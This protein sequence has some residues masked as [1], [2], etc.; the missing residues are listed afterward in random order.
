[1][2][3]M[4]LPAAPVPFATRCVAFVF[5]TVARLR[6][7]R[8]LHPRGVLLDGHAEILDA[9]GGL[10][11]GRTQVAALV[12]L[13]RGAG[14][15]E[16][17]PDFCGI[18]LRLLDA[19]GA[20]RHQD[21]LVTTS[22]G[23]RIGRHLLRPARDTSGW[24]TGLVGYRDPHGRS[25]LF[26]CPPGPRPSIARAAASVPFDVVVHMATDG[27]P[28]HA[29]ARV[30]LTAVDHEQV[31]RF[32]PDVTSPALVPT[33]PLNRWRRAAYAASR[34]AAPRP[35]SDQGSSV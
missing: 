26:G 34:A 10:T 1:M 3:A 6:R 32:D 13:S 30:H 22:F 20:G 35:V 18:A 23:S 17:L 4:R 19:H 7:D 28:W 11:D 8:A 2:D 21:L 29:V 5:G 14:V 27:G 16:P 31:V 15:P 9:T 25:V 33:G 24:L 12:R